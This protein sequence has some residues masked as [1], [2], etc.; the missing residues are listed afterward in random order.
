MGQGRALGKSSS[1]LL[2]TLA[3]N[4]RSVFTFKDASEILKTSDVATRK[5]LSDLVNKKWLIRLSRGLY[6]IIPLSAGENAE[7]S[8]N[9]Y[10]VAKYLVEPR[11]Y[12]ISHYSAMEIHG[13]TIQPISTV[14][15]STSQ[16][17]KDVCALGATFHFTYLMPSRIWGTTDTWATPSEKVRVSDLERTI[18]DCLAHPR[19]CGGVS[20]IAKGLY[21]LKSAIDYPKL[22]RDVDHFGSNAVGKRLGFL[23]ELYGLS[24]ESAEKL[25][26][27]A[28]LSYVLLDPSLP[29]TGRYWHRWRLRLNISLEELKQI[30]KT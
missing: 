15:I 10:V 26:Q 9:W 29:P 24:N 16:R 14:F 12:Y 18:I 17:K 11:P 19:L 2:T 30:V 8:E 21:S 13:M 6:L 25:K 3:G 20:E 28:N 1:K 7:V 22:L 5:L 4:D 27:S 23:L